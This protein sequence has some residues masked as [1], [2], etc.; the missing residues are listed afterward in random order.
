MKLIVGIGNPG[1]NYENTR[2][3]VGFSIVDK[4][5]KDI[6]YKEKFNSLYEKRNILGEDVIFIKPLTFVN[7]SG[8]SVIKFVNYYDIKIDDILIIQDDL[9]MLIGTYKLKKNSSSG[10][11]NGIKS[12]EKVL[13][14]KD[15][16]RL[17][18]GILNEGKSNVIDFV[19]GK[20][21]K[22]D[23]DAIEKIDTNKIIDLF[24]KDGFEQTINKYKG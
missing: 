23:K 15:F 11:H 3:N 7:L 21:S 1:K 17:K 16:A 4:Y 24:I 13:R 20:F 14:T 9:D 2:H 22:E 6:S 8:E 10:G 12:I 19:L 5:L 18:I